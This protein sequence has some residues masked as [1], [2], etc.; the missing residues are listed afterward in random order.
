MT[1]D[2]VEFKDVSYGDTRTV[3]IEVENAGDGLLEFD[4]AK[5]SV[6]STWLSV[7]PK[8][9]VVK[10]GEKLLVNFTLQI[11][12]RE[13]HH[14]F[15]HKE[16]SETVT[17]TTNEPEAPIRTLNVTC[18]YLRSCFGAPL[19]LL[20]QCVGPQSA[21]EEL[22][23][24]GFEDILLMLESRRLNA[25]TLP[26]PKELHKLANF[27]LREGKTKPDIFL[28]SGNLSQSRALR[29]KLDTG[30]EFNA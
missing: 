13:A 4:I 17:M 23:P 28:A 26:V 9:G 20:N 11:S 25:Y 27:I 18:E 10:A 29:E 24:L 8:R 1:K 5:G 22:Q 16:V 21:R 15:M 12:Q 30:A 19:S 7:E 3:S 14:M 6:K 2:T